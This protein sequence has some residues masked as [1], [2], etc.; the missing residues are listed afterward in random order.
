M[1]TELLSDLV[2]KALKLK[3]VLHVKSKTDA[4][5]KSSDLV[6]IIWVDTSRRIYYTNKRKDS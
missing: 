4:I 2:I 3:S 6:F 1:F 5:K